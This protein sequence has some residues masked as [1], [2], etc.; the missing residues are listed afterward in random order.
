MSSVEVKIVFKEG[1]EVRVLRGTKIDEDGVF[2]VLQRHDGRFWINKTEIIK[3]E[4]TQ[5]D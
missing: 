3:I 4:E 5:H 1:E 2:V